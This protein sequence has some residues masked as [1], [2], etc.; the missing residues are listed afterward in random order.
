ATRG[1]G[2]SAA[3]TAGST[4]RVPAGPSCPV[5]VAGCGVGQ[6][7]GHIALDSASRIRWP[8]GKTQEVT[9]SSSGRADSATG[10]PPGSEPPSRSG[11]G[12]PAPPRPVTRVTLPSRPAP[13]NLP[14]QCGGSASALPYS[15][16]S[17]KPRISVSPGSGGLSKTMLNAP[18]PR[19]SDVSSP[20]QW[21]ASTPADGTYR[22]EAEPRAGG[23]GDRF[24]S[25]PQYQARLVARSGGT[26]VSVRQRPGIWASS[27]SGGY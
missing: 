2:R 8:R 21:P 17:G 22:S 14:N 11:S 4:R 25:G 5:A 15:P 24:R 10:A 6:I 19:W 9:C 20:H 16:T 23:S 13:P 3:G 1:G 12:R 27:G 26:A 18:A 7:I